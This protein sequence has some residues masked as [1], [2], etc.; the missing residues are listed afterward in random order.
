MKKLL[1]AVLLFFGGALPGLAQAPAADPPLQHFVVAGSVAGYR[2]S[3]PVSIMSTGVQLTK[4]ISVA[5]EYIV[6]PNDSSR[7]RYGSG[8]ANYTREA[9]SLLPASLKK[10]LVFDTSNYLVTFQV[11]AGRESDAAKVLGGSRTSHI[12]GNFGIYGSR[13]VAAH[14]S[15]GAGYKFILGPS[16]TVIKIPVGNLN[17]TF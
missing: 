6:N 7:P 8:V 2:G 1:S 13:P 12:I 16:S 11:G 17:F 15:L 14:A 4:N 3:E 5:Y 10:K 9:S